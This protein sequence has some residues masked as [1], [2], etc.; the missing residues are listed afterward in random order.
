[1]KINNLVEEIFAQA[2]ALEQSGILRNT[3]YAIGKEVFVLNFDHTVLLRFRLRDTEVA[4]DEPISFRANDYDS[5]EF[6]EEAGKIVFISGNGEFERRK[7]CGVPGRTP[8]QIR[9]L[10]GT[11]GL[12]EK[13]NVLL[14][15]SILE[16]LDRDLSHIEFSGKK[17]QTINLLQRNIYDGSLIEIQRKNNGGFFTEILEHNFGPIAI[18][19]NDFAA[20][21]SFQDVMQFQF[22]VS[23]QL[24]FVIVQSPDKNKRDMSGVIACCLYDEVIKIQEARKAESTEPTMVRRRK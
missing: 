3:I 23:G 20:L 24:D 6:K 19:T 5:Q 14:P 12:A 15:N 10:F 21:F 1:M 2:V 8:E 4:F 16:L 13:Q 22:P 17:G 11:F 7:S 18:K 9:S